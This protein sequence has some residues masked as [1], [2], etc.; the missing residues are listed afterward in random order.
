M[1]RTTNAPTLEGIKLPQIVKEI[2]FTIYCYQHQTS[3]LW[4]LSGWENRQFV[5]ISALLMLPHSRLVGA[6][7]CPL[8]QASERLRGCLEQLFEGA[9]RSF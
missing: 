5:L 4:K 6:I 3:I 2:F 9:F 7:D 1:H 8:N